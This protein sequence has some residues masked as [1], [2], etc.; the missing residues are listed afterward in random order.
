MSTVKV[1]MA[2]ELLDTLFT[3]D[4]FGNRLRVDWGASDTYGFHEP[5]ITV[6]YTD[7]LVAAVL[8]ELREE[9]AEIHADDWYED[10]DLVRRSAVLAAIDRR[11]G[12]D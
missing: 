11:L 2:Q 8:R 9:V 12:D 4:H 5:T 6:D 1:L 3:R 7:N 10:D